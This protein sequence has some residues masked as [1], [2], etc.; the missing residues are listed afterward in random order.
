MGRPGHHR[1]SHKVL[2]FD[3]QCA[4]GVGGGFAMG[5]EHRENRLSLAWEGIGVLQSPV[6]QIIFFFLPDPVNGTRHNYATIF[7]LYA[8]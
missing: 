6:A 1:G 2:D 5:Y 7:I 8:L 4:V 3:V